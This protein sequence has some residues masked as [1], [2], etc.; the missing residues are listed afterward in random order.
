LAQNA[1]GSPSPRAR[2]IARGSLAQQRT[3]RGRQFGGADNPFI[4]RIALAVESM[5][6]RS[7]VELESLVA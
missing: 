2:T 1:N 6:W 5:P 3:E 7:R 4:F